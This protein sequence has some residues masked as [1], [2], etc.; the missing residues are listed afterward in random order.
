MSELKYRDEIDNTVTPKY[1]PSTGP[2]YAF[3][4]GINIG[5]GVAWEADDEIALL[6]AALSFYAEH[7]AGCRL[8]HSGGD[9]HRQ[10]LH[11]DGGKKAKALITPEGGS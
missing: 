10:A 4:D 1:G 5:V 6:R 3:R 8:V 7:G 2:E 11:E 9:K